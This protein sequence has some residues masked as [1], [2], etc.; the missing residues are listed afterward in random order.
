MITSAVITNKMIREVNARSSDEQIS[1]VGNYPG[2]VRRVVERHRHYFPT[3]RLNLYRQI[4]QWL[5]L[6]LLVVIAW[7]LAFF[8]LLFQEGH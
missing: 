2:K 6:L 4:T 5:G 7:R 1:E 8:K 3:S